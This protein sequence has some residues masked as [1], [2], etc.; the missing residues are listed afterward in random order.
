[1]KKKENKFSKKRNK[2]LTKLPD[3][4]SLAFAKAPI[5]SLKQL[6][7]TPMYSWR[8]KQGECLYDCVG[9]CLFG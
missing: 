2:E 4:P 5:I 9:M 6:G 3:R 7:F 1:M 8:Q